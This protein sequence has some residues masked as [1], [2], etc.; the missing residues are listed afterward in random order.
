MRRVPGALGLILVAAAAQAAEWRV[1]NARSSI[2]FDYVANDARWTGRFTEVFGVG[3]FD[4]AAPGDSMLRLEIPVAGI[5]LGWAPATAVARSAAWFDAETHPVGV[6]HLA[7][8]EPLGDGRWRAE[9]DATL[10]G[11]TRP[12]TAELTL[13]LGPEVA[14]ALGEVEVDRLAFGVGRGVSAQLV[15]VEPIIRVRFDITAQAE[16]ATGAASDAEAPASVETPPE[17][18]TEAEAPTETPPEAPAPASAPVAD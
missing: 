12:L 15:T 13:E 11:E 7:R 17:A 8:V 4:P 16:A 9:G 2:E 1:E 18:A 3:R 5:D 6:F 10:R 14:R